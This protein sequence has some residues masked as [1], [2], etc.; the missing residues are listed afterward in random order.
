MSRHIADYRLI[1][2]GLNRIIQHVARTLSNHVR[3]FKIFSSNATCHYTTLNQ[4]FTLSANDIPD[5]ADDVDFQLDL[6]DTPSSDDDDVNK[7]ASKPIS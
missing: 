5:S 4:E 6:S 3:F 7:T 1:V 2:F